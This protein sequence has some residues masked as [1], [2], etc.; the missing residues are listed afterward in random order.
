[1]KIANET[2]KKLT[3]KELNALGCVNIGIIPVTGKPKTRVKGYHK[4]LNTTLNTETE[5][6]YESEYVRHEL[7][8]LV[9]D[10]YWAYRV[11]NKELNKYESF[12]QPLYALD[13]V[14]VK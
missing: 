14:K 7:I 4:F 9:G 13:F 8:K 1:M 2:I 12:V 6:H 11:F 5:V 3:N 10:N